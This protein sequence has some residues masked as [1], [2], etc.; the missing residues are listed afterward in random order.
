MLRRRI[1]MLGGVLL[2]DLGSPLM[3][4]GGLLVQPSGGSVRQLGAFMR[5]G[6]PA[7]RPCRVCSG[8]GLT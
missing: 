3:D 1:G 6:G 7:P 5:F 8:D 2:V 4:I